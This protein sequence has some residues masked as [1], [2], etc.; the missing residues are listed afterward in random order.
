METS[1]TLTARYGAV[2]AAIEILIQAIF[3]AEIVIRVSAYWPSPSAF[4]RNGWNVFDFAVVA[5][6][7]LP[8]VGAFAMVA[9]LARL[10]RV[11]RWS[12]PSRNYG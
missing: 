10:L 2:I 12:P 6:S 7:L 3:V 11:T 1:A 8:Q 5:A 4:F 9:R